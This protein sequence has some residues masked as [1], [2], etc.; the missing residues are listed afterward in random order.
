LITKPNCLALIIDKSKST[1][2]YHKS[3]LS[4]LFVALIFGID[5]LTKLNFK[6]SIYSNK[7][8]RIMDTKNYFETVMSNQTK[9]METLTDKATELAELVTPEFPETM[10]KAVF[11]NYYTSQKEIV[12][13]MMKSKGAKEMM[14]I[15]P[16]NMSKVFEA[17]TS[18]Y[19]NMITYYKRIAEKNTLANSKSMME[20]SAA[21]Y[22][23]MFTAVYETASANTKALQELF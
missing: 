22:K 23:D 10:D 20:K 18:L 6:F 9:L 11:E 15:L 16:T 2:Y 5:S 12:E 19:N 13:G 4:P 1:L 17:N 8:S 14:D 7:K 3:R 21:L